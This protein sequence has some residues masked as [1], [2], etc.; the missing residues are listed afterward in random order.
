MKNERKGT[1]EEGGANQERERAKYKQ[2][3]RAEGSREPVDES[4]NAGERG[5][6]GVEVD[7]EHGHM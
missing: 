7:E 6:H 3:R 1:S 2:L 4:C 5:K